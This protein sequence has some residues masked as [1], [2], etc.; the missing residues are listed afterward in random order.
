MLK[1]LHQL[2]VILIFCLLCSAAFA[3]T[4]EIEVLQMGTGDPV[5]EATVVI[6]Q[7]GDY[8]T[9]DSTGKI[10]FED[11]SLP[12]DLKVLSVGYDTL[13]KKIDKLNFTLY[14][15]PLEVEGDALEVV[16]E[17]VKEKASK[18]VLQK[19]ELR[20]VAGTQGDPIKMIETLPGVITKPPS[21]NSSGGPGDGGPNAIYVRGSSGAENSFWINRIPADYLYHVWGI[22][23]VNPSLVDNFNIFLGGYPVEYSDVLGGVID[24]Q[25]RNPR[26][27]RLHQTYRIALNES[28]AL[29]E[30][31]I[32]DKQSFYV[33]ARASY[34]DK[35]LD[36]F[37]DDIQKALQ[38][39]DNETDISIITLPKYW[40]AQANWH[41]RL[42]K[43]SVDLYYFGSNDALA[44]DVNK[45]DTSDPDL[46]G[47][48]SA[49][50]GFHS[51]GLNFRRSLSSKLTAILTAGLKRSNNSF[52]IGTDENGESFG[53]DNTINQGLLHPQLIWA[54]KKNHELTF[55]NST[56]YS[57]TPIDLNISS[58]PTEENF[59]GRNFSERRK[60]EVQDTM[61][62]ASSSPYIKWRWTWNKLNTIFGVRYTKIRGSGGIDMTDY[63]PRVSLE[64]QATKKLLLTS[65]WG[66]YIQM[67]NPAQ[68]LRNYG[69]PGLS[70]TQAEHRIAGVQYKINNLWSVQTEVYHKPMKNLVLT[71]PFEDPPNNYINDGEGEAV[72][73]DVLIKRDYGNRKM[74][75][76]SYSFSKSNRTLINGAD[77]DF[78]ADQPH[79]INLVWNQPF[80]GGWAKWS[81]GLK[82]QAG[83]G[84]PYTPVVGRVAMCESSGGNVDV[85]SNQKNPTGAG[86]T[87]SYW[88]PIYAE[89]NIL[90]RPFF[91]QLDLRIDRL[92]RYNTWTLK[93]YLD[94]LNVTMQ[95]SGVS[96]DYG[97]DYEDYKNPKKSGFPAIILPFLGVEASF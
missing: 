84:Q 33:A 43:G 56:T 23:I 21:G 60:F 81:W 97:K 59:T 10:A 72:G 47:R 27:D 12:L 16:E 70:F 25:L 52:I 30:G 77:R 86:E 96:E 76:L 19:E 90:R 85:C 54:P 18:I 53:V 92:V 38:D 64:Y 5:P 2:I 26:T 8:D 91:H 6:K 62:M 7:T 79:S 94:L 83:S 34:I 80:T 36:P 9:T 87:L 42:P 71:R 3:E 15:E 41:Y 63:S 28:A 88:N 32:N 78:S 37:I 39:N 61:K 68:M 11:I 93:W 67:P 95:E 66:R 51:V 65:S 4:L 29:V 13:E 44:F 17:R 69:N 49:E 55:G 35:L 58:L 22:S 24:I 45:L 89:R 73:F 1:I 50:F 20:S 48:L 75:W 82:L 40:D 74:G 14:I 31:P 57:V 46:L